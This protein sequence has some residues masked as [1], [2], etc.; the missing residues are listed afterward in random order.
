MVGDCICLSPVSYTHLD[1][2]KR[3]ILVGTAKQEIELKPA[4]QWLEAKGNFKVNGGTAV[5]LVSFKG[6]PPVSVCF[7]LKYVERDKCRLR[8]RLCLKGVFWK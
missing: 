7:M 6:K 5:A 1:V 3:Q 8:Q 4:G 2:Y